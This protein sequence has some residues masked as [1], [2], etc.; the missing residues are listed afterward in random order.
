M[1]DNN[2]ET[3]NLFGAWMV[4]YGLSDLLTRHFKDFIILLSRVSK[5]FFF[6]EYKQIKEIRYID[7]DME[8][9]IIPQPLAVVNDLSFI[10]FFIGSLG[11]L[12]FKFGN[13]AKQDV[14]L[15][16]K[17]TENFFHDAGLIF[18]NAPT[19]LRHRQSPGLALK[20]LHFFDRPRNCFPS[21]HVILAS[22]SY[23]KTSELIGKYS[24]DSNAHAGA[25]PFCLTGC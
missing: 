3:A 14:K 13:R 8:S 21:L 20:I 6:E 10:P 22:Y 18:R 9:R 16:L 19:G 2:K 4:M 17:E 5:D 25:K 15:F 23:L 1:E 12:K 11:Y 24:S 7:T